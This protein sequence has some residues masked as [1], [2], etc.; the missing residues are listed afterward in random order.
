MW[1]Q[2]KNFNDLRAISFAAAIMSLSYSTIA[3]GVTLHNGKQPNVE[4]NLN[5]LSTANGVLNAF[6]SLGIIAFACVLPTLT[7]TLTRISKASSMPSTPS[8]SSPSRELIET[9]SNG[10]SKPRRDPDRNPTMNLHNQCPSLNP[11]GDTDTKARPMRQHAV[12]KSWAGPTRAVMPS[13]WKGL[14]VPL[15]IVWAARLPDAH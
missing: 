1:L 4:Y 6:N 7:V 15:W 14:S 11:N 3:I 12:G 10:N 5:G 9:N 13:Q 2:L 8:P